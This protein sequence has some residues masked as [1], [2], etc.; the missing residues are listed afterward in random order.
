M[1]PSLADPTTYSRIT[2]KLTTPFTKYAEEAHIWSV[3]F[4][5][6]GAALTTSAEA[7]AVALDLWTPIQK[8]T[9]GA[10]NLL[11]W[12]YYAPG[13]AVNDFNMTYTP[14][15]HTGTWGAYSGGSVPA[16]LEVCAMLRCPVGVNSLGR[17]KYLF[18]H[19]H[20]CALSS[21]TAGDLGTITDPSAVLEQ[22]NSGAGSELL[23][24]V[25]PTTGVSG[26]P[27]SIHTAAYTR[28]LRRGQKKA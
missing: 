15:T 22:Y 28:Q 18:K 5:L 12:L 1:E 9:S 25:D 4:S 23:V 21:S 10:T 13:S 16:Q 17:T 2:L 26:G 20:D 11:S 27:W 24:P 19:I 6:S 7:E 3:K 14:G 8:L